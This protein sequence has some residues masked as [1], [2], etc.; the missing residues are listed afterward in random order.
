MGLTSKEW[1]WVV[2]RAN[3]FR[4]EGNSLL[5]VLTD[6]RVWVVPRLKQREG[7]V[8]HVLMNLQFGP[9]LVAWDVITCAIVCFS[10]CG[11]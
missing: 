3:W 7:V 1:D 2:H 5:W 8:R 6:G 4:W 9:I 11:V 10:V